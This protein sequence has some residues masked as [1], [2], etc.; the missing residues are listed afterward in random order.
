MNAD[1][2]PVTAAPPRKRQQRIRLPIQLG[3][4]NEFVLRDFQP[5]VLA[6]EETPPSPF[7]AVVLWSIVA[8]LLVALVWTFVSRIPIMTTAP[9]KFMSDTRTKVVQSLNAG[10]VEEIRAEPGTKVVAGQV[11]VALDPHVDRAKLVSAENDLSLNR[12]M[13]QRV[14]AELGPSHQSGRAQGATA[15]MSE[16][17]DHL[18]EAQLAAQRSK[19]AGDRAQVR[20]AQANLAAGRAT[21]AEYEQRLHQDAALARSAQPLVPEGAISGQQYTQLQDQVI[22]DDGQLASQRQVVE[23]LVAAQSAAQKQLEEDT[24]TFASARY[25]DLETT[26]SK[27]YDLSSQ[28]AQ[29]KRDAALDLLRSPVD[30]TVQSVDVASLGTVVQ[31]GQTVATVEP[32]DA[33]LIVEADLP[34]QDVGFVKIGQKTRIK[35]TAYPFEQYGSIAGKVIWISPTAD[36]ATNLASLPVGESHQPVTPSTQPPQSSGTDQTQ[37]GAPPPLFYRVKVAPEQTWLETEGE[38]R[39]MRSGMTVSVDI[40]TG[41]RRVLDFF[42]DPIVKYLN[43]GMAV[44]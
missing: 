43:D 16:L 19:I 2:L 26:V 37:A 24:Q 10:T 15:E 25:Q 11:L 41:R 29:A 31:A 36:A 18:A 14:M 13:E 42:L 8:L 34:A 3:A 40:E 35:V 33:P 27:R 38:R 44:R 7:T 12:A 4:T 9:G 32:A 28:Y 17:E 22:V 21:L 1:D 20:E 39:I 30:G 23:Q 5:H 6:I